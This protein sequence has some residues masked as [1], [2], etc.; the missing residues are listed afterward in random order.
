[1]NTVRV[2]CPLCSYGTVW[3]GNEPQACTNCSG[4]GSYVAE[5]APPATPANPR[6]AA[7]QRAL[8]QEDW[9]GSGR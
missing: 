8:D 1:M 3:V 9:Y 4:H 6:D 5:L 2:R 7:M